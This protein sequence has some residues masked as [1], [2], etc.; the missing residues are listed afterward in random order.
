[1]IAAGGEHGL[2]V[3]QA[4]PGALPSPVRCPPA[5]RISLRPLSEI[6]PSRVSREQMEDPVKYDRG[7]V[8]CH[9]QAGTKSSSA[10]S[11]VSVRSCGR[12]SL[13]TS[14]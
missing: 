6:R 10:R 14:M 2:V 7:E 12:P 5:A 1:V 8:R 3:W 13:G 9:Q 4:L 11:R